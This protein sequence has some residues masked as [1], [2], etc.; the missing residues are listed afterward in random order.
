M[1]LAQQLHDEQEA[2]RVFGTPQKNEH[3]REIPS[4]AIQR[5]ILQTL[6]ASDVEQGVISYCSLPTMVGNY[7]VCCVLQLNRDA[8]HSHHSLDVKQLMSTRLPASLVDSAAVEFLK[9]CSKALREHNAGLD[10]DALGREP[11]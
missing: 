5:A 11:E 9:I 1:Q 4:D 2:K 7:K 3:Q 8:F 10:L 6:S